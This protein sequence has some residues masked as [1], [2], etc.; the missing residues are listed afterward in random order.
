MEL[1]VDRGP[2]TTMI[3]LA[4]DSPFRLEKTREFQQYPGLKIDSLP[5]LAANKLLALFGRATLRDFIDVYSLIKK[6]KFNPEELME[7]AGIKDPG[8]D[9]YWLGVA[10]QRI[11]TF[12]DDSLDML[13]LTEPIPFHELRLF[14]N[15]WGETIT[16]KLKP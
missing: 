10:F 6:D 2:E 13:L 1:I 16:E 5:D 9:L 11:K 8:F 12:N 3:H 7:K 15:Q 14:F 4:Q